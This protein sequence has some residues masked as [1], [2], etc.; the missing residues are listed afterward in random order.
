MIWS[1]VRKGLMQSKELLKKVL[2]IKRQ[3]L[4]LDEVSLAVDLGRNSEI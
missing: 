3:P 2:R 4:V 1:G